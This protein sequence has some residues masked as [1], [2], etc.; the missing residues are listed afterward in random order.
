MRLIA[1]IVNLIFVS[2]FN[3]EDFPEPRILILEGLV[4]DGSDKSIANTLI[5]MLQ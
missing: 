4:T 3:Q 2:G 1:L 5:G